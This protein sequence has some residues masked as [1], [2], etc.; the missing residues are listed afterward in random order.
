MERAPDPS[1]AGRTKA[2]L[3]GGVGLAF[4]GAAV[5]AWLLLAGDGSAVPA[6]RDTVAA[7]ATA[8]DPL[9][10]PV[11]PPGP[12]HVTVSRRNGAVAFAWTYV[13]ALTTDQY[14][15]RIGNGATVAA[16]DPKLSVPAPKSGTVCIAVQVIRADG[17]D[18]TRE[19]PSPTCG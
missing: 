17:S 12:V 5:T 4:A 13:A 9:V 8:V 3:I 2:L 16:K 15:V 7:Q 1:P 19:W 11:G 14:R 10:A 6:P 18:P